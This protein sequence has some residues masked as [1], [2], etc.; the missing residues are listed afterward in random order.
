MPGNLRPKAAM[1]NSVL[2]RLIDLLG[3]SLPAYISDSGIWSYPGA[4][5]IKLALADLVGDNRSL[6][7]RAGTLLEERNVT[8]PRPVYPIAF[9]ALHDLDLHSLLPRILTAMRR[10]VVVIEQMMDESRQDPEAHGLLADARQATLQ[11]SDIFEDLARRA[12]GPVPPAP[13]VS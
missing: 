8:P 5:P 6:I 9:T 13:A 4:E 2:S 7:E 3:S 11:H 12:A 1:T 10:Q